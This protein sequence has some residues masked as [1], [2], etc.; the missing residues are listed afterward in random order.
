MPKMTLSQNNFTAGV[1]S[2]RLHGRIDIDRYGNALKDAYNVHPVVHGGCKRRAGTK[3]ARETKIS[4][5]KSTL[6][7]FVVSRDVAY[8]LEFGDGYFRAHFPGGAS[9]SIDLPSPYTEAQLPDID[10]CQGADTMF[11]FHPDVPIYRLRRFTD[12]YFDLSPAPFTTTP[13]AEQGYTTPIDTTLS[14]AT[15][16][17]GRTATNASSPFLPT[18]VGRNLLCDSG[19]ANIVAYISGTQVTVNIVIAFGSTTLAG[20]RWIVDSSPQTTITPGAA[21]PVGTITTLTAAANAWRA[22]DTGKFVR[23]NGGLMKVVSWTS[24]TVINVVILKELDSAVA[25]PALAWSLEDSVWSANNGYPRCGTLHEQRL[26]TAGSQ[27][28]PQTIWGSR[29]AEY[30]DF[31]IG[32]DDDEAYSFTISSDQSN[33]IAYLSSNTR[34]IAYTYGGESS[35]RG[36]IEKPIT[37]TNVTVKPETRHGTKGV[38][39]ILVGKESIAVQRSGRKV[40]AMGYSYDVDGFKAPDITVLAEHITNPGGVT[41]LAFQQEPDLLIW[42]VRGDGALLSCTFDREQSVT[43]WCPH[44]T[45]GAFESVATIPNGSKDETWVIVRRFINGTSVRYVELMNND[46]EPIITAAPPANTFP[47]YDETI[48]YGYTVDCG[49]S[50][51]ISGGVNVVIPHLKNATVDIIADGVVMLPRN[52]DGTGAITLDRSTQRVLVGLHFSSNMDL[53]TPGIEGSPGNDMRT[54]EI[55]VRMLNTLGAEVYDGDGEL[56]EELSFREFGLG[57]LDTMPP[58]FTGLKRATK[59][60][61]EKGR[62]EISIRQSLPLPM[63]ILSAIRKFTFND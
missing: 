17:A 52:T 36:G 37:P 55:S 16:G 29:I 41:Q 31:T 7:P 10:Y 23:I 44:Y 57:V 25:S 40:R 48:V 56:V 15:V 5:K 60:G 58:P 3:F 47:P 42:A 18:D 39:P 8:M 49:A 21:G 13:F 2:P 30:L 6:V 20:N 43:A 46:F 27:K 63:H 35:L 34:L 51:D 12:T 22:S 32:T 54:H 26:V 59:L 14:L 50:Y 9:T 1:L 28:Y 61:W 24:A 11:L 4:A 38:R 45:Y 19:L 53:L 33:Q 62:D